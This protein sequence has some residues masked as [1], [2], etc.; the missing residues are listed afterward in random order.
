MNKCI[1]LANTS[2]LVFITVLVLVETY[3]LALS[4]SF[5]FAM[6][7]IS[8]YFISQEKHEIGWH[9]SL[10]SSIT[11]VSLSPTWTSNCSSY[12][13]YLFN[14]F[15]ISL[16]LFKE[17]KKI[18]FYFFY[19]IIAF[20]A[21]TIFSHI[22]LDVHP[23]SYPIY[24]D[25]S[26]VIVNAIFVYIIIQFYNQGNETKI[27]EVKYAMSLS[28][29]TLESTLSGI[30]VLDINGKITDY[31]QYFT[32]TWNIPA[33]MMDKG[34]I[35]MICNFIA[36]QLKT[37]EAFYKEKIINKDHS[38]PVEYGQEIELSNGRIIE[39]HSHPQVLKNKTIGQ[40]VTFRDVSIIR[41][42]QRELEKSER[43]FKT[44]F[45]SSPVGIVIGGGKNRPLEHANPQFIKMLGYSNEELQKME[46]S[47]ITHPEDREKHL[48]PREESIKKNLSHFSLRKRYIKKNGNLLWAKVKLNRLQSEDGEYQGNIALIEDI[49][50]KIKQEQKIEKLLQELRQK[51]E[52]LELE[53]KNR[54]H[55][56]QKSNE[57]LI[58]SNEDLEQF[59]YI[60]SHDLQ[61]PL[62]MVGNFVQ[63]IGR[64]YKD[65]IDEE[66]NTY[67]HFA[68][69][70]VN[71]MSN[72]IQN[73]L[74][75]SRVGRKNI[76]LRE[77]SIQDI[78]ELKLI[79]L[80]QKIKETNAQVSITEKQ[81]RLFCEPNQLG[82]VFYNLINNA[83]KFCKSDAPQIE[84]DWVENEKE[85][86]F[87]VKDNGIGIEEQYKTKVFEI[88][89][90]LN[91][92]E[93]YEGTGI[94]LALCKKIINRH[95]GDIWFESTL[96]VGTTFYFTINKALK[97]ELQLQPHKNPIG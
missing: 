94:G 57:E 50:E 22:F 84:I 25:I 86:T 82:I 40:V 43:K 8:T 83:L 30:L 78:I 35:E 18:I 32:S 91:R 97:N 36:E 12:Y 74:K 16:F 28:K 1:F 68:V 75:Y 92:R 66:G 31:N 10:I 6:T 64:N 38:I 51:N 3:A 27:E 44:V 70:G 2:L 29:A 71:R 52:E 9:L 81:L 45:N 93:D 4:S 72:L 33:S 41:R 67:I 96:G 34:D 20:T 80:S 69:D 89:K 54:T 47:E 77:I 48:A 21:F 46:V 85:W 11:I 14:F 26:T 59:A 24:F 87:S 58:R 55:A 42:A 56:L 39:Y 65:K 5:L 23:I 19:S 76:A 53:V 79:D 88:F 73:L 62:R 63:L 15:L 13:L 60:A 37:P 7:L 49:S 17:K 61:E 90:R 95:K